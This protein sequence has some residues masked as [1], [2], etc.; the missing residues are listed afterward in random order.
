MRLK[1]L[2]SCAPL[3]AALTSFAA[4]PDQPLDTTPNTAA[5]EPPQCEW[6]PM[7]QLKESPRCGFTKKDPTV[8]NPALY[9][10]GLKLKDDGS[11]CEE[12]CAFIECRGRVTR[13]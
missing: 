4:T 6:H 13:Q 1:T 11:G 2:V 12:V 7:A 3:I 9:E 8:P 5:S 10:C